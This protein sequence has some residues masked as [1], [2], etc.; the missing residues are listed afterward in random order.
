MSCAFTG[1][2]DDDIG[3]ADC[4][5]AELHAAQAAVSMEKTLTSDK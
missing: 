3:T 5:G 1:V 4:A 2:S